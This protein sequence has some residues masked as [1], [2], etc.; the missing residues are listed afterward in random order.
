MI[1]DCFFAVLTAS[2]FVDKGETS[3]A[4]F[5]CSFLLFFE[6]H[7]GVSWCVRVCAAPNQF[8]LQAHTRFQSFIQNAS[9]LI[10]TQMAFSTSNKKLLFEQNSKPRHIL[11]TREQKINM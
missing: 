2:F 3:N 6:A 1:G 5:D 7:L 4:D 11:F 10:S 9:P 8:V